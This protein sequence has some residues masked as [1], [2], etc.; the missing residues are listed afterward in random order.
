MRI[1]L[2]IKIAFQ[3]VSH[4]IIFKETTGQFNRGGYI[5][6][7][8]MGLTGYESVGGTQVF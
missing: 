1:C 6:D 4:L 8:F 7:S 5:H 3:I 2:F